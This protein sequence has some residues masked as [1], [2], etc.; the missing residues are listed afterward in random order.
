MCIVPKCNKAV[1]VRGLC[2]ACYCI[3]RRLVANG[4][5][6]WTKLEKRGFAKSPTRGHRSPFADAFYRTQRGEAMLMHIVATLRETR[7]ALQC[8]EASRKRHRYAR[9]EVQAN[10]QRARLATEDREDW[11]QDTLETERVLG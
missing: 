9:E 6:T 8:E 1:K 2:M 4:E 11:L 10:R 5:T 3:A 7:E